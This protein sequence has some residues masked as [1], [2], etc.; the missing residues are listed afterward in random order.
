MEK[1]ERLTKETGRRL[2]VE[3]SD[4]EDGLATMGLREIGVE[5]ISVGLRLWVLAT[6]AVKAA[7]QRILEGERL[8]S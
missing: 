6:E 3:L 4:K 2:A 7:T 5:R 8:R 1:L